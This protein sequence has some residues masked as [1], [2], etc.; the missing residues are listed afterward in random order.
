MWAGCDGF[1]MMGNGSCSR[2]EWNMS[3]EEKDENAQSQ[4][5]NSEDVIWGCEGAANGMKERE[6]RSHEESLEGKDISHPF[7]KK[8]RTFSRHVSAGVQQL[9]G[10]NE[11]TASAA[12][13][14]V[15]QGPPILVVMVVK[16]G[17][18]RGSRAF[19]SSGES[20]QGIYDSRYYTEKSHL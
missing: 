7:L 2:I 20:D 10:G 14:N 18:R 13:A 17:W 3:W 9:R 19:W 1:G 6:Q 5:C 4:I 15:G 16:A 8:R 12:E 11:G